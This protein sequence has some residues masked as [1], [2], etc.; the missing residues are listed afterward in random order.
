[1]SAVQK[2]AEEAIR[3][4]K[5]VTRSCT[6]AR[7]EVYRSI[8][9]V[10]ALHDGRMY[11]VAITT[12]DR[13]QGQIYLMNSL[14]NGWIAEHTK[15]QI[16]SILNC[17]AAKIKVNVLPVEQQSNGIYFW[18]YAIAFCFYILSKRANPLNAFLN[19]RKESS[20]LL[21]RLTADKMIKFSED[22]IYK[23]LHTAIKTVKIKGTVMQ[24]I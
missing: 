14:F 12:Y 2:N 4:S 20:H 8:P 18:I 3:R 6:R 10:Q 15:K 19:Q 1:M 13:N 11:W 17:A 22:K 16:C 23:M 5:W 24:I 9:F 7:I 21:H